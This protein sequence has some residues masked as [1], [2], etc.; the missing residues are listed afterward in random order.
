MPVPI[1]IDTDMGVDDAIAIT[2]ALLSEKL[3]VEAL[4]SVGGNVPLLQATQ[5]V[6]RLLRALRTDP[7]PLVGVGLDQ[8]GQGLTDARHV[9]GKDGLGETSWPG[10]EHFEPVPCSHAYRDAVEDNRR[11]LIVVCIGPLT[12]LAEMWRH[13]PGLLRQIRRIVIMGGA[14]WCKGNVRGIAE[15]NFH[16][17]PAAAELLLGAELPIT[18]VPLDLTQFLQMDESHVARLAASEHP[19]AQF[20]ASVLDWPLRHGAGD[21]PPG[22][23][24]VH[25]AAAIGCLLW[26]E[27]FL[28]TQVAV[29]VCTEGPNRGK[30]QPLPRRDQSRKPVSV[31]TS[32]DATDFL[33]N[34]LEVLCT[35]RFVV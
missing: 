12:N 25:D 21:S 28:S 20:L 27:L 9:F 6:G 1:L 34:M 13:S 11:E 22:R 17:D 15:F 26:P 32:V 14:I 31:L 7:L 8:H 35:Q 10:L 4:V 16:R 29:R 33:E 24:I 19:A 23:F 18:L 2:L 5:N 30:C 3:G